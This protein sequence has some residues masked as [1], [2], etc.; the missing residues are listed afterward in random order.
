MAWPIYSIN[1]M[2][3]QQAV[4]PDH[5]LG[6]VNSAMHLLFRG[7]LPVGAFAG[8]AIADVMG[9]RRTLFLGAMGYLLTT[10]WLV[11]SPIWRLRDL[12]EAP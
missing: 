10:G 2:S 7:V 11:F 5:L 3:L 8:G 9:I 4:T 1:K 6:R 12:P